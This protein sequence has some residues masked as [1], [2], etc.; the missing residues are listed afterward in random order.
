MAQKK[1]TGWFSKAESQE[2]SEGQ[3]S[4]ECNLHSKG[5]FEA[6]S[7]TDDGSSESEL[8]NDNP[9]PPPT[10]VLKVT[11]SHIKKSV[12]KAR[13]RRSKAGIKAEYTAKHSWLIPDDGGKGAL[14]KYCEVYYVGRRGLPR[15]S[16][17]MFITKPFTRWSKATGSSAKNNKLLKHQQ[18]NGHGQEAEMCAQAEKSGSVFTQLHNASEAETSENLRMLSKYVKVA[19]WLMKHEVAHTTQYESLTSRSLHRPG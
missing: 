16:D 4:L 12:T 7:T 15:G 19:Y 2:Q 11:S 17:G 9:T 6:G 8:E 5:E 1:L 14:Y 3:H 13:Y 18:S 10:K